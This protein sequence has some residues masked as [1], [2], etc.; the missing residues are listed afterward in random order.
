MRTY[1]VLTV[2]FLDPIASFHGCG[3]GG[4]PEWPPSPL[5]LFQALVSGAAARW[6]GSAFAE[7]AAPAIKW[8]EGRTPEVLTPSARVSRRRIECMSRITPVT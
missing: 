5:R 3:D 7:I 2:Q 1:L 4:E 8:L 6:K